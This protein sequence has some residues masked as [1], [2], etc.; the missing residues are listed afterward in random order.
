VKGF[1]INRFRGDI[2]LLQP[3]LDWLELK[4]GKPVLGV[5]PY[6]QGLHL[7]AED[8]LPREHTRS[9]DYK[10]R[11]VVPALPRISNHTDF[12]ALRLHPDVAFSYVGPGEPVPAADLI[13]LP[14]SK[15]VRADLAWLRAHGWEAALRKHLRYGGKLIDDPLGIEGPSGSSAGFGL[16]DLETTLEV[17]KQLRNVSGTLRLGHTASA[18]VGYEIHCGVSRGAAL[19]HPLLHLD[20]GRSDGALSADGQIAACY[21]HGLFDA[22]DSGAALLRW[23]GFAGAR[24]IDRNALREQAIDTLADAIEQHL[25]LAALERLLGIAP[26]TPEATCGH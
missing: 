25:D 20:D 16:L 22:P 5:L 7:D 21:L 24:T 14:G 15:T 2:A 9:G 4:T 12:D 6:L 26:L 3:G 23:A 11:V 17:H 13:V 18:V 8:A 10:L 19:E 1:V